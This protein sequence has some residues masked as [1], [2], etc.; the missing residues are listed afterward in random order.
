[1]FNKIINKVKLFFEEMELLEESMKA[2]KANIQ[3]KI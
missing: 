2:L 1:M 3:S